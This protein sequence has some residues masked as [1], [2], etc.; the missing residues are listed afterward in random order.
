MQARFTAS[1]QHGLWALQTFAAGICRC[2]LPPTRIRLLVLQVHAI[3]L[4]LQREDS[5][6]QKGLVMMDSR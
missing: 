6:L 2:A 5:A 3:K 4:Y 1:E